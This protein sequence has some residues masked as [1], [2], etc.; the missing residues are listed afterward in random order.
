MNKKPKKFSNKL[1]IAI[2]ALIAVVMGALFAIFYYNL[3]HQRANIKNLFDEMKIDINV[4]STKTLD[5]NYDTMMRYIV[6]DQVYALTY[7]MNSYNIDLHYFADVVEA[8]YRRNVRSRRPIKIP[9]ILDDGKLTAKLLYEENVDINDEN[10]KYDIDIISTIQ[11]DLLLTVEDSIDM[12]RCYIETES[13]LIIVADKTTKD[14]F[15][16]N[17]NL[18]HLSFR[19]SERYINATEEKMYVSD[20][21]IDK[22]TGKRIVVLSIPYF[23]ENGKKKGVV[24]YELFDDNIKDKSLAIKKTNI[25]DIII[26]DGEN[27]IVVDTATDHATTEAEVIEKAKNWHEKERTSA[28]ENDIEKYQDSEHVVYYKSL[29]FADWMI[30][31]T[32]DIDVIKTDIDGLI[33]VL[34]NANDKAYA[35]INKGN[36]EFISFVII[37]SLLLLVFLFFFARYIADFLSVPLN[38]FSE[39]INKTN[40]DDLKP[41]EVVT[42]SQ[43]LWN[44]STTYNQIVEKMKTYVD[45]IEEI[46]TEKEKIKAELKVAKKIQQDMLPKSFDSISLRRDVE[47]YGL[48]VPEIEIGGDFYNYILIGNKLMLII[49]DVSGSGIPAGLFMAK[50]N[51]LLNSAISWTTSP[52]TILS[53]INSNLYKNNT[54]LYFVTIALYTIDL[55]TRHVVSVNAG[56]EDSILINED[57]VKVLKE[58]RTAPIGLVENLYFKENEFDLK[59]GDTLFLF[60]DGVVEAINEKE[61]LFTVARLLK[62]LDENKGKPLKEIV[63]NVKLA[64]EAHENGLEQYDDVTMLALRF[65]KQDSKYDKNLVYHYEKTFSGTYSAIDDVNKFII[66]KLAEVYKDNAQVYTPYLNKIEVCIEEVVVNIIEY[67]Y[68]EAEGKEVCVEITIDKNDDKLLMSF[69]DNGKQFDPRDVER[70][71]ILKDVNDRKIG[72]LGV[73]LTSEFMDLMDYEYTDGK[74][75]LTL[76]KY[77]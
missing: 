58:K 55:K 50:V 22:L 68:G 18:K 40:I 63:S 54:E 62:V 67:A 4:S 39:A 64:I 17:G 23:D 37:F 35:E 61:E 28:A 72:G 47:V 21:S 3:I 44:L 29:D 10:V 7:A 27:N 5:N 57:E 36:I 8:A 60:T 14:K 1:F 74:N 70:P 11:N 25:Y 43:E 12:P 34:D 51:A 66:E 6:E 30:F 75:K 31:V 9:N 65:K 52:R 42:S 26:V 2:I 20:I 41:V 49:A 59:V 45:N 38:N 71:N 19:D 73:Y 24:C 77:L 56:H 76:T 53:Y 16:D 48:N 69:I 46:T 32:L 33:K 13:G 15:D